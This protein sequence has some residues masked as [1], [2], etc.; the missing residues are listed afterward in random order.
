M[1]KNYPKIS[2]VTPSYN[3]GQYIE[4]TILSIIEQEY[5]HLEYIIIDGGS[6]DNTVEIIKKYEKYI[7]Y[8]VSE[9]DKGQSEALNKG[10]QKCTGEIFNWINSDD[11]LEPKSLFEVA[12]AFLE[13]KPDLIIGKLRIF[14]DKTNETLLLY[15]GKPQKYIENEFYN[16]LLSQPSAFYNMQII[17][18]LGKK[19]NTNL[20]YV[21]DLELWC[22]FR[23]QFPKA[24]IM[25]LDTL[26]AHFR[27][28]TTSKT[29]SQ[30]SKFLE[31]IDKLVD[32]V[33]NKLDVKKEDLKDIFGDSPAKI[34]GLFEN[35]SM[36]NI[37]K[38][39]LLYILLKRKYYQIKNNQ[40]TGNLK[41]IK[42]KYTWYKIMQYFNF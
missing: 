1:L 33:L 25:I 18:S 30:S 23:L 28:H 13:N 4:Q 7:T 32:D 12:E 34:E 5:P 15:N 31:E 8:W 41:K 9:K 35:M 40:A 16:H 37:H 20:H 21:M 14:E 6:T 38:N 19:V 2:I 10:L 11:Y 22:R 29:V 17:N 24:N 39:R 42:R 3:Q 26:V 27:E 36:K